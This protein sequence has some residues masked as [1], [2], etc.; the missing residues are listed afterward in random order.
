MSKATEGQP[1]RAGLQR[2]R[3]VALGD[4]A[5]VGESQE[6]GWTEWGF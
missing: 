2:R 4:R 1:L 5:D 6:I 3:R